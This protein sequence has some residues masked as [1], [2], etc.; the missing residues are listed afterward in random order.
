MNIRSNTNTA[1]FTCKRGVGL[2]RE[3]GA[4]LFVS[5]IFLVV[6]SFMGIVALRMATLEERM[7]GNMR[8]R[9]IAFQAAESALRAAEAF[10][11]S[12]EISASGSYNKVAKSCTKGIYRLVGGVPYFVAQDLGDGGSVAFWNAWPW[13][14]ADCFYD[15]NIELANFDTIGRP[16]QKPRYVIE[17]MPQSSSGGSSYRVTAIGWGSSKKAVVILQITVSNN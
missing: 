12:S 17:E 4:I 13:E 9:S 1:S 10:L 14:T 16:V 11:G 15:A 7:A 6:L 5:L 8:D 3:A 2:H